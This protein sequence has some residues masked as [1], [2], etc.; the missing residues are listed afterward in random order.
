MNYLFR[1][2]NVLLGAGQGIAK[3]IFWREFFINFFLFL[4][5]GWKRCILLTHKE[6]MM[7]FQFLC[8]GSVKNKQNKLSYSFLLIICWIKFF[9]GEGGAFILGEF[10]VIICIQCKGGGCEMGV[11][12]FHFSFFSGKI[13]YLFMLYNWIYCK[14]FYRYKK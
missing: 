5:S 3:N 2:K 12:L 11:L 9:W 1:F 7:I 13:L 10:I 8:E 6:D 14:D 4:I